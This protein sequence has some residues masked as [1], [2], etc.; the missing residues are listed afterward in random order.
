MIPSNKRGHQLLLDGSIVLARMSAN[1]IRID[2]NYLKEKAIP[3]TRERLAFLK[4]EMEKTD[5]GK[6]W[7]RVYGERM[8]LKAT[9]QLAAV[10]FNQM[11]MERPLYKLT[12]K[13][14]L[15]NDSEVLDKV[16]HPFIPIYREHAKLNKVYDTYLVGISRQVVNGFLRPFFK[17]H[18]TLTHR[19]SSSDPNF[20]NFPVRNKRQAE[21]TRRAFIARPGNHLVEC[22][23]SNIE[24]RVAACYTEDPNLVHYLTDPHADMH[25]DSAQEL[26]NISAKK[27]NTIEE[28]RKK[29]IRHAAKNQ[30]VFPE[31]YGSYY[32]QCCQNLWRSMIEGQWTECR[33]GLRAAGVKRLGDCDDEQ[34][35][36]PGTFEKHVQDV[37][38]ILWEQRFHVY[39]QWKRDEWEKYQELGHVDTYTGFRLVALMNRKQVSNY[40]IQG[41]AFHCLLLAAILLQKEIEKRGMKT[42]LVGQIHDSIL[43]DVPPDELDD[44][45]CLVNEIMTIRVPRIYDWII[46]QLQIEADVSPIGGSWYDKKE[47]KIAA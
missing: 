21:L 26:F 5:V 18:S 17:L 34:R 4:S 7:R 42:L 46:L 37:E 8:K 14:R 3:E 47:V 2:E 27:W 41:S 25:R 35:P 13:G 6:T 28:K 1:G 30:F 39:A 9:D 43:A 23:Y 19:S 31:F 16:K 11:G 20:Q 29:D 32:R 10:L 40:Q 22:D 36:K 15:A 45:L 12:K 33:D 24:V 38:R 44:F